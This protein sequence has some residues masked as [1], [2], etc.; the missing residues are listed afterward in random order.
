M[1]RIA[2]F[3]SRAI[4]R[5]STVHS[6]SVDRIMPI[7]SA[8]AR[9]NQP[10]KRRVACCRQFTVR[11]GFALA[12]FVVITAGAAAAQQPPKENEPIRPGVTRPA[13]IPRG[14]VLQ[15]EAGGDMRLRGAQLHSERTVPVSLRY[16]AADRLA[17]DFWF[18][19]LV[20]QVA[21][22]GGN[23]LSGFGDVAIGAQWVAL[24]QEPGRP[25]VALAYLSKL[26]TAAT[27]VGSGTTDHWLSVLL[28]KAAGELDL[29]AIATYL[30]VGGQ[31]NRQRKAGFSAA[32]ASS[33]EFANK[34]G[35]VLELSHQTENGEIP[36]GTYALGAVTYRLSARARLDGG[37][38]V[39]LSSDASDIGIV[40]G[41]SIG[42]SLRRR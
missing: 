12:F 28:T 16:S 41:F 23:R 19:A 13:E 35:Y 40:A 14:G 32:I 36:S 4:V 39:G 34:V 1:L 42:V 38:R 30:N 15:V 7:R 33:Q 3:A 24:T 8:A 22:R 9:G 21:E 29:E 20:S 6:R 37:A 18:D 10:V 11:Y 5:R 17:V 2:V 25:A 31:E 26:P 27:E